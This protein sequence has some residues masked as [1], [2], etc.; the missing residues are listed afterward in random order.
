MKALKGVLVYIG[1]VL[2]IILVIAMALFGLMYFIPSF[3][4]LGVGV[5][6]VSKNISDE[7]VS[8]ASPNG[9]SYSSI[10]LSLS[11]N[12]VPIEISASAEV[13]DIV[14]SLDVSTFGIS[15]DITEYRVIKEV[16]VS[17]GVLKISLSVTEPEG[18]ISMSGGGVR[19]VVPQSKTYA[20]VFNTKSASV[21]L[22]N[23]GTNLSVSKLSVNT[24]SGNL[25]Y[26]K[27]EGETKT[28][29]LS[30]L[31][32]STKSGTM[33]LSNVNNLTVSSPI[34]I[35]AERG[36]F[37]FDKVNASFDVKGTGITLTAE[38]ITCKSDGFSFLAENGKL[39]VG[40]ITSPTGAENSIITETAGVFI[41]TLDGKTGINTSS[42]TVDIEETNKSTVI[43]SEHGSVTIKRA[44]DDIDIT[45][46]Y[47]DIEV[48][49]YAKN[50]TFS[51][52]RGNITVNSTSDYVAGY[53]TKINNVNGNISVVNKINHLIVT[54]EGSSKVT[55]RFEEIKSGLTTS[56]MFV[57][58]IKL[59]EKGYGKIYLPSGNT[60]YEFTA[61][62]NI[63]GVI[64]GL[65]SG[66]VTGS[67]ITASSSPQYYPDESHKAESETTCKFVFDG[68]MELIGYLPTQG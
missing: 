18:W 39:K 40:S 31:N 58:T 49:S 27:N 47:G 59:N 25:Y 23:T 51:S 60:A 50:G 35:N 45:T 56:S 52:K 24:T 5:T 46:H 4:I 42:G 20:L 19:V 66:E 37:K 21:T 67:S 68:T 48:D 57:H 55:V 17:G 33:N 32:L 36:T 26:V 11:S 41:T 28:L 44:L 63:S 30:A 61:T 38:S 14:Y 53:K 65:D 12:K 1:I 10:Q 8:L 22:N 29:G 9:E 34:K 16:D 3:R 6:H 64:K 43:Q 62:G 2:A 13:S 54:T 15:F 7:H